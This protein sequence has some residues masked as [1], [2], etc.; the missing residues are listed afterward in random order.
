[1][2]DPRPYLSIVLTGRNDA[3]G[4]DFT[5]RFIRTLQFNHQRLV[6]AGISHEFVFVEWNPVRGAPWLADIV[7]GEVPELADT[8]RVYLVDPRYQ[9]ELALNPRLEFLEFAAKNVGI[10]RSRGELVLT[11]NCDIYLGRTVVHRLSDRSLSNATLYRALRT[12]IKLGTDQSVVDWT[13]LE[14]SRNHGGPP[15]RLLPPLYSGGTG[16]FLLL[17][18]ASYHLLGGFNEVYRVARVLLD[19]NFLVKAYSNG[20]AI[21]DIGGPVYHVNHTGSLRLTRGQY[22]GREHEAPWG[23]TRWPAGFVTYSNPDGWGLEAA[24]ERDLGA[25]RTWLEFAWC[26]VPPLVDLQRVVLPPAR[27]GRGDARD[28]R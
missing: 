6:A 15:K 21:A 2:T 5:T 20:Y 13:L 18:R 1:V 11:T 10:R 28:A 4:T 12:D 26:A 24:P 14:D 25:G 16:D 8:L 3:Y 27:E 23:D 17:D 7:R 9:Q 22:Q 19:H